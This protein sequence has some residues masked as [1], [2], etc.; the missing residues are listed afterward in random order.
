MVFRQCMRF[1]AGA[2]SAPSLRV[3]TVHL[4]ECNADHALQQNLDMLAA[5]IAELLAQS[6]TLGEAGDIDGAQAAIAQVETLKVGTDPVCINDRRRLL[7]KAHCHVL[8]M[9]GIPPNERSVHMLLMLK[10]LNLKSRPTG[11][12]I[13]SETRPDVEAI[14]SDGQ[15]RELVFCLWRQAQKAA[16]EREATKVAAKSAGS[17]QMVCPWSGVIINVDEARQRDHKSGRN[18]Q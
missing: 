8:P 18:Y 15:P 9:S 7:A 11:F 6:E 16:L 13:C 10:G 1:A 17:A 3:L 2:R 14:A 5:R 12:V 4:Q